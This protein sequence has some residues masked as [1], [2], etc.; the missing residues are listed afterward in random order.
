M[1]DLLALIY[2]AAWIDNR[3]CRNLTKDP[4]LV[5]QYTRRVQGPTAHCQ[6]HGREDV[7][8]PRSPDCS[9]Q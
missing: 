3:N 8:K 6:H 9:E 1:S 2:A 7:L 5:P 4:A